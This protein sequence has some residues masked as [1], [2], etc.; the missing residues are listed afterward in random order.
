ATCALVRMRLP[1]MT[2]PEAVISRGACLVHGRNGA[3]ARTVAKIFTTE[4][5]IV[6]AL[7]A[8]SVFGT[9]SFFGAGIVALGSVVTAFVGVEST[10]VSSFSTADASAAGPGDPNQM[11][12]SATTTPTR[13]GN[14]I[15]SGEQQPIAPHRA[16]LEWVCVP[17]RF[18]ESYFCFAF[19]IASISGDAW[20]RTPLS[21]NMSSVAA[22]MSLR[23]NTIV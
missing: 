19:Q 21:V 12:N 22:T 17:A 20:A 8:G 16:R 10:G 11:T 7:G 9:D 3:G 6:S 2:T 15:I 23:G 14:G 18:A 13:R 5:S 4:F 1:S